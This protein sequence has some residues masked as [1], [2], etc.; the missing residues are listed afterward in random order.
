M[1]MDMERFL[2]VLAFWGLKV[3]TPRRKNRPKP[4]VESNPPVV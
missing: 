2:P 4:E 1:P 3:T